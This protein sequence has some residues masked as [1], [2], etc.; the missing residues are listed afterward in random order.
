[1]LR[2]IKRILFEIVSI[3]AMIVIAILVTEAYA[4]LQG[5]SAASVSC[6]VHGWEGDL[7]VTEVDGEE[8][9]DPS[10]EDASILPEC[11]LGFHPYVENYGEGDFYAFL[12]LEY[13]VIP[14]DDGII[15]KD[16]WESSIR[17]DGYIPAFIF[18]INSPWKLLEEEITDGRLTAVY[19]YDA[20]VPPG[21]STTPLFNYIQYVGYAFGPYPTG[22]PYKWQTLGDTIAPIK[23]DA[24]VMSPVKA[25]GLSWEKRW[26]TAQHQLF[27]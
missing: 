11:Y 18:T 13:A 3:L 22:S 24:Y 10:K 2:I 14:S 16:G 4:H 12:T 5:P 21:A 26:E 1:M 27:Y 23:Y 15:L 25:K 7:P 17:P 20:L 8:V 19:Y 9:I 6:K